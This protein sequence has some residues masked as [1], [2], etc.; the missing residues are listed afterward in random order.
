MS[1]LD[2]ILITFSLSIDNFAVSTAS[3]CCGLKFGFKQ[4]LKVMSAF[5]FVGFLCLILGYF[6]GVKLHNYIS[7]WDHILAPLILFYIGAKMIKGAFEEKD[8]P[9][10]CSKLDMRSLKVLFAMALATNIDVFA[11]G[12]S[13]AIYNVNILKVLAFLIFFICSAV[14]LGFTLGAKLGARFG[15]KAEIVGGAALVLLSIKIFWEG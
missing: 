12:V 14:A 6:G 4:I 1:I 3:S 2:I 9:Q 13:I 5:S 10:A 11:A 15:N 8:S 7:S